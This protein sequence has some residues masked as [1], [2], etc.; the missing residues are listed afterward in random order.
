M[1]YP[2]YAH[3]FQFGLVFTISH[4]AMAAYASALG[5]EILVAQII[6]DD[7]LGNESSIV[8]KTNETDRIDGGAIRGE[9]LFH[10]FQD[11]NIATGQQVYF[12]NPEGIETILSRVTGTNGS[13][14]DG[15]LG[16]DG[17]ASLFLLNPNGL[18]FGPNAQL[19]MRGAF[20]ASTAGTIEFADGGVFSAVNPQGASFL[21]MSVPLGVQFGNVPQFAEVE[22]GVVTA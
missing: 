3:W 9:N 19:D 22:G 1:T 18:T 12:V 15:L 6:P 4:I 16:V 14:I 13:D 8:I 7:T 5:D 11:F 20:T 17:T 2:K 10:S 21:T